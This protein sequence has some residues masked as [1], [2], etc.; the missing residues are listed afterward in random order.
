MATNDQTK[1]PRDALNQL[2]I[3][4]TTKRERTLADI[5]DERRIDRMLQRES[6]GRFRSM[7]QLVTTP[8]YTPTLRRPELSD[9][10]DLAQ[11]VRN[12]PRRA[13]R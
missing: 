2:V 4:S 8:N 10:Y 3:G 1:H 11:T 9:V 6:S 13:C 7:R 5:K 12:D